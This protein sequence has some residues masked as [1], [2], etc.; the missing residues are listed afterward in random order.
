MI[1]LLKTNRVSKIVQKSSNILSVFEKT[2]DDLVST[3]KEIDIEIEEQERIKAE[4]DDNI[5]N[6]ASLKT[7]HESVISKI[8]N[9][10]A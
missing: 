7:Q 9:F 4:A 10:L 3:N 5:G 2:K 8:E 6:L 1:N